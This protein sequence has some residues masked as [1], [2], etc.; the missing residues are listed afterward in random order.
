MKKILVIISCLS[1]LQSKAFD[2]WWHAECTRK[3]MVANGFSGDARL[4]VQVSNYITDFLAAEKDIFQKYIGD[5]VNFETDM[6]YKFM[7]FDAIYTNENL[8]QNW[9]LLYENTI[10]CLRK[11]AASATV[12]PGFRLIIFFNIIGASLHIVQ[13]FYSHSNWV[14]LFNAKKFGPAPVW[15]DLT[16]KQRDS[17]KLVTGAYPDGAVPG[18]LNHADLN[19]DCSTR[20][21][22]ID[23]VETAERASTD[24]VKRIMEAVPEV[25]WG[26]LK[27]YNIQNNMALKRFLI[28]LDATFLTSSSIVAEHFDG[29][30][31][32]KYV[33]SPEK[34]LDR[35]KTMA[36]NA[37]ILTVDQYYI[38][39]TTMEGNQFNL[40][41]PYWA[42][43]MGY[44]I[45][46]D[47]ANGLRHNG[48]I[49]KPSP[50]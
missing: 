19:K 16:R 42:G 4:A 36:K 32:S 29:L 40:P 47:L 28:K 46:R 39:L 2:T 8:E 1:F 17:L 49:Y 22:N 41:S 20:A 12:K 48:K 3:A 5:K 44:H 6:S 15:Y 38:N 18:K 34:K 33:F 23:A 31:P 14:N 10:N 11:Y 25:P 13:D 50:K 26:E 35:E 27:S 37:L 9:K 43:F 7:H 45:V 21:L 30:Q 24:W